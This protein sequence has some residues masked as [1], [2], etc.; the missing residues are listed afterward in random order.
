MTPQFFKG[1]DIEKKFYDAGSPTLIGLNLQRDIFSAGA[2]EAMPLGD[3]MFDDQRAPLSN[4]ISK[5]IFRESYSQIFDAFIDVGT[6]EAYIIVFKKIFG[7][8]VEITFTVPAAGRLQIDIVATGLDISDFVSRYIADN[9]YV[10][11]NV[12]TE[13]SDQIVFQTVKGFAT[14]YELEQML[15]EMVPAGVFTEISLTV[16]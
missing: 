12:V 5:T 6:F 1:D 8:D 11:D 7:E 4:A 13:D 14:Q 10:F 9:A 15:F 2:Y 16:G 3:L